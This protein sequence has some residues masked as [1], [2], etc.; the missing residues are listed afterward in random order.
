MADKDKR[1][2]VIAPAD[3]ATEAE[4]EGDEVTAPADEPT[5]GKVPD[6]KAKVPS[7][8]K[9][10]VVRQARVDGAPQTGVTG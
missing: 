9:S 7:G 1:D 4:V 5:L 3:E 6:P 8:D 10:T 2:E